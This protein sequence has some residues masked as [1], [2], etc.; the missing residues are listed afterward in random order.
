[1][2]IVVDEMRCSGH[3]RCFALAPELFPVDED[4]FSALRGRGPV[5]V[6][7]GDEQSAIEAQSLCPELAI[8]LS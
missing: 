8:G 6:P 2:R 7:G 5:E 3:A 1:M 4:G